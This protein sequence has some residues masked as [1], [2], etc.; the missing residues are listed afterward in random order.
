LRL[1]TNELLE[2]FRNSSWLSAVCVADLKLNHALALPHLVTYAHVASFSPT[3]A[4]DATTA[5][6]P[7]IAAM[8]EQVIAPIPYAIRGSAALV[9]LLFRTSQDLYQ[10]PD[11]AYFC[12]GHLLRGAL[13]SPGNAPRSSGGVAYNPLDVLLIGV[14]L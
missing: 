5:A 8:T 6:I 11:V 4:M 1:A 10:V 9:P 7:A 13:S 3:V 14:P 2:N 12:Q